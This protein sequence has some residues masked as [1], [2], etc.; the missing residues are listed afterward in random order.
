[1][2]NAKDVIAWAKSQGF[3]S[4]LAA[5]DMH[6]TITYSRRA[7]NWFSI[8]GIWTGNEL[9]ILPGGPRAVDTIGDGGAVALHFSADELK[10]RNREMRE[11]GCSWDY[12]EYQPHLTLT[13][14][15]APADLSKVEPYQG[16]LVFGPEIFE[17]IDSDWDDSLNEISLSEGD[18]LQ[19]SIAADPVDQMVAD[20]LASDG[21]K[22][23]SNQLSAVVK[24]ISDSGSPEEL[25]QALL[26]ALEQSDRDRLVQAL[27]RSQFTLRIAAEAG[28]NAS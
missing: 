27:A 26:A 17:S 28:D 11:A 7:I 25:D 4:T 16:K 15:G 21:W 9:V 10:W 19:P 6:V 22:P 24:A 20:L 2:K 23:L 13:Y 14:E 18:V 1:L 12:P 5:R 8:D 3:T